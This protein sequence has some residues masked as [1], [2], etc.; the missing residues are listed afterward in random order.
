MIKFSEFISNANRCPPDV[1]KMSFFQ[2]VQ[3]PLGADLL[4]M[5]SLSGPLNP[6]QWAVQ[7]RWWLDQR[8]KMDQKLHKRGD[9]PDWPMYVAWRTKLF[10]HTYLEM[11]KCMVTNLTMVPI[12]KIIWNLTTLRNILLDLGLVFESDLEKPSTYFQK[13]AKMGK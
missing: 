7:E 6:D 9:A 5:L 12:E 2:F 1:A 13:V 11:Q 4:V 10:M 3:S 8:E